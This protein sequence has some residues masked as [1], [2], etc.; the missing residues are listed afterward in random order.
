VTDRNYPASANLAEKSSY[1]QVFTMWGYP[2]FQGL[3][4]TINEPLG[5]VYKSTGTVNCTSGGKYNRTHTAGHVNPVTCLDS[6]LNGVPDN[7][8][9]MSSCYKVNATTG[10]WTG[11]SC[12]NGTQVGNKCPYG[13]YIGGTFYS[14]NVT[15]CP[16]GT[17]LDGSASCSLSSATLATCTNGTTTTGSY[18]QSSQFGN[19]SFLYQAPGTPAWYDM[20]LATPSN[21]SNPNAWCRSDKTSGKCSSNGFIQVPS[22]GSPTCIMVVCLNSNWEATSL[23]ADGAALPTATGATCQVTMSVAVADSLADT[24]K[25][26]SA[27]HFFQFTSMLVGVFLALLIQ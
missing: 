10:V 9:G 14:S 20:Y 3:V 6:L 19:P 4:P 5:W 26:S 16:N 18:A 23:S 25:A 12:S 11:G 1:F 27:S 22:T 24:L 7:N 15:L 8:G 2:C 13:G 17:L 21:P